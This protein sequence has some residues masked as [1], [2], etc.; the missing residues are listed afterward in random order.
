MSKQTS[1][2]PPTI[3]I[4]KL[5]KPTAPVNV[6]NIL[7]KVGEKDNPGTS[8]GKKQPNISLNVGVKESDK[9]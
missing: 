8:Q 6:N 4:S 7:I 3:N 1:L 2:K 5:K 9:E